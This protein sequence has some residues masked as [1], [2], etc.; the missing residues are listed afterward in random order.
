MQ[1]HDVGASIESL[2]MDGI[3]LYGTSKQGPNLGTPNDCVISVHGTENIIANTTERNS[4][5]K[6][7]KNYN[8]CVLQY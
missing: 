6:K 8:G 5:I 4:S 3:N 7:G 2:I 1:E